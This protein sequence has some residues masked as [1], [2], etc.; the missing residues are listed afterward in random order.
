MRPVDI[1]FVGDTPGVA[2]QGT[3]SV[4]FWISSG[5]F[6]NSRSFQ[7]SSTGRDEGPNTVSGYLGRGVYV[8]VAGPE[9]RLLMVGATG[10]LCGRARV[11]T[12]LES[13]AATERGILVGG[14][15]GGGPTV[16]YF[17]AQSIGAC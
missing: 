1:G 14:N 15:E 9:R 5:S 4:K 12:S 2:D 3:N 11:Q 10:E 13:L 7:F 16:K 6:L 17:S 8:T